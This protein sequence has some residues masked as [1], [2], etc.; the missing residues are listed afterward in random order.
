MSNT[1]VQIPNRFEGLERMIRHGDELSSIVRPVRGAL[2]AIDEIYDDM[3]SACQGA[4]LVLHGQP[5]SGKSTFLHTL[6]LFR[7]G[8]RTIKVDAEQPIPEALEEL[9]EP[10]ERLR[11]VVLAGREALPSTSEA[12]MELA[13]HAINQFIR[14]REG[15]RT[16]VVW[17]C[18]GED[19]AQRILAKANKIGGDALLGVYDK[20][21]CFEGPPKSEY[22]DIARG[23]I[24]ALNGGASLIALGITEERARELAAKATT[25]GNFFNSLRMEERR[26]RTA[27]ANLLPE[28]ARHNLWIVVIAGNDPETEVGTLTSGAHFSADIERL[29]ASTDANVVQDLK[30]YPDKLGLLGRSFDARILYIPIMTAMS[31]MRDYADADLRARLKEAKFPVTEPGDGLDRLRESQLGLAFQGQPVTIRSVGRK[32]GKERKD[33]FQKLSQYASKDDG[34]LNRTMGEALEAAG[35][36]KAYKPE[37][38]LG[39][40]QNRNSDVLC[41][42]ADGSVRLEFMWRVETSVGDIARYVLEKLYQYGKAIGYLNGT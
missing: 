28:Q 4:F 23:T 41:A 25:I 20:G 21:Y 9:L 32:P 24:Q 7:D 27:L 29:L 40:T 35:L 2:N 12:D 36:I 11:V 34:A 17:P 31:I 19:V 30:R 26:N 39:V 15:Q 38:G 16:L 6:K 37:D 1:S 18:T 8:V 3:Q 33:E 22:V 5:G 10:H 13:L 14:S 42:T